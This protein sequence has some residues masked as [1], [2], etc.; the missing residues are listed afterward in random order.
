MYYYNIKCFLRIITEKSENV[1]LSSLHKIYQN[2]SHVILTRW[3]IMIFK[4]AIKYILFFVCVS[5]NTAIK[6]AYYVQNCHKRSLRN[7]INNILCRSIERL[8]NISI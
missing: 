7:H 2:I 1:Y 6:R 5:R 3:F 4:L 8:F